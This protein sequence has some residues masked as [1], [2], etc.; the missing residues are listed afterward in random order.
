MYSKNT[1][2]QDLAKIMAKDMIYTAINKFLFLFALTVILL[3]ICVAVTISNP[4]SFQKEK[5]K[6]DTSGF[7]HKN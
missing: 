7:I 3:G 2:E 1:R 4:N 6:A 5:P